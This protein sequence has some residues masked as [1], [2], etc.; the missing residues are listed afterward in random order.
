MDDRAR[1][2]ALCQTLPKAANKRILRTAI[3][4]IHAGNNQE[5]A[6]EAMIPMMKQSTE[7]MIWMICTTLRLAHCACQLQ[8][9]IEHDKDL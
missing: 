2:A 6:Y 9:E 8:M 1:V 5:A 3:L 7:M 4:S